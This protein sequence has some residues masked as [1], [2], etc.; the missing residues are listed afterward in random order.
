MQVS[1]SLLGWR[2]WRARGI[3]ILCRLAKIG[4]V[5]A[6]RRNELGG[7]RVEHGVGVCGGFLCWNKMC[8]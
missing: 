5:S 7:G 4:L 2:R 3:I 8:V 1:L 6:S